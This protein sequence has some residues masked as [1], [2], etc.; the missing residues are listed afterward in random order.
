[1]IL[2]THQQPV[3]SEVLFSQ[4][5]RKNDMGINVFLTLRDKKV[6]PSVHQLYTN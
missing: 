4:M 1:M 5:Y 3:V 2:H 6:K